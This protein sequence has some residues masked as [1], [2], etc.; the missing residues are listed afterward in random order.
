MLS[1]VL[2]LEIVTIVIVMVL[3]LIIDDY[4]RCIYWYKCTYGPVHVFCNTS[5]GLQLDKF[6]RC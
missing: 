6:T 1:T 4:Y 2:Q 3:M 5:Y